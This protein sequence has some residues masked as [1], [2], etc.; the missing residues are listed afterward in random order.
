MN[1][2]PFLKTKKSKLPVRGGWRPQGALVGLAGAVGACGAR[3]ARLR[4]RVAREVARGQHDD[5]A[6]GV[7][8]ALGALG[9]LHRLAGG[10]G[11]QKEEEAERSRG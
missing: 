8:G 2:S 10:R 3:E 7:E 5:L 4:A 1:K 11:R 9:A 6:V